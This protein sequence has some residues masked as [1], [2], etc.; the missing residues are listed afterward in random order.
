ME[1]TSVRD[2]ALRGK[3]RSATYKNHVGKAVLM[4]PFDLAEFALSQRMRKSRLTDVHY[5]GVDMVAKNQGMKRMETIRY[6]LIVFVCV[7]IATGFGWLFRYCRFPETN[8]VVVYIL[9]VVLTARY[10]KGYAYGIA[11]AVVATGAFNGFFTEPYFTLSV[12]DPNYFITFTIMTI[13]S[14]I[15]SALTSKVKH[16]A[17]EAQEKEAEASALYQL[18]NLLTDATDISDIASITVRMISNIMNCHAACLCFDENGQPE[19]SFI[20]QKNTYEQVRRNTGDGIEIRRRLENLR[21]AYEIGSEFYDWPIYGGEAILG[22]LR[23]PRDTAEKMSEPQM[24]LLRSMIESTALAMDRYRS[25]QERIKSKEDVEQERYRGNLLRSISHDLRTPLSGIMGTSEMLM[26]MTEK[27]DGRYALAGDIYKDAAWLHSLVENIL[28]L[29]RLQDGKLYLNKQMEAVEEVIGVA[30]VAIAKRTPEREITVHFPDEILLVPMDAK[31]IEQVLVNL[32]DN[33]LKHTSPENEISISV[34]EN[35][36]K[37]CVE[38]TVADRGSGIADVDFPHVFQMFYTA[39]GK[40][41]DAQRGIGLG[42]AICKSIITAH[43]GTISAK[44]RS[45]GAGAEFTFTL[46]T[47]VG[48]NADEK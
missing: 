35:P 21:T 12:N 40:E 18:T 10:T 45:D 33:A 37:K 13:T 34:Q 38:F 24:R 31:L 36:G 19:Q 9:S 3:F 8:I 29:T 17:F 11:A 32:L 26:G 14:V 41:P 30:V 47:E 28:S 44:N 6:T 1:C 20:Q 16:K 25:A 23:I 7:A 46:P 5:G 4:G 15:T 2:A 39:R 43:G 48:K 42:L 27:T 22:I